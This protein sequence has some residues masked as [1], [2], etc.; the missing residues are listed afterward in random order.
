MRVLVDTN[1][2]LDF[3]LKREKFFHYSSEI[4][5]LLFLK[6]IQGFISASSCTDLFYIISKTKNKN[7]AKELL[8]NLMEVLEVLEV[9]KKIILRALESNFSDFEDSVQAYCALYHNIDYIIT[10]NTKDYSASP[11]PAVSPQEFLDNFSDDFMVNFS[12][13]HI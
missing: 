12:G 4:F 1:V 3:L 2:I 10:R 6:R 13:Q 11:V 7:I 8:Y 5:Q 9:N